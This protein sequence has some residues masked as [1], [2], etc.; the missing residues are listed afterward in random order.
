MGL[1]RLG[2]AAACALS[3]ALAA[4]CK[5]NA[6]AKSDPSAV[7]AEQD[8]LARRD[9]LLKSREKLDEERTK[10]QVKIDETR[11]AG[12]DTAELE[13]QLAKLSTENEAQQDQLLA[14]LDDYK[15]ELEALRSA[16]GGGGGG[17][18]DSS[19]QIAALTREL[20]SRD[21]QLADMEKKLVALAGTL[22]EIKGDIARN[23]ENC[24]NG[25][26]VIIASP[27]LEKGAKYSK[28]DV[29]PLLTKARAAMSKKGI[30]ASDLPGGVAAL[31]REATSAMADGDYGKAFLAA[32]TL[33]DTIE[34]IRIDKAFVS[35][36]IGRLNRQVKAQKLDDAKSK[37]VLEWFNEVGAE[38][39]DG[40]FKSANKRLNQ[41]AG[42]L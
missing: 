29:E 27:K 31:E 7:K 6:V 34:G 28:R 23:A 5:D 37:Q 32:S 8:L 41:I 39:N 9:A 4:G 24:Q 12:G 22:T 30:L 17:G 16:G 2:A 21:S 10:L 18:G 1:V 26:G 33:K 40:D 35:A 15:R 36:K 3:L 42:E 13:G 19:A 14:L 38:Y 11:A 20:K 25:G